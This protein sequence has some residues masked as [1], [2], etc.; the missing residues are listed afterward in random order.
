[1]RSFKFTLALILFSAICAIA[2]Q[3]R[4]VRK[5]RLA[6][7]S[8]MK[9]S[10]VDELL[11]P[12]YP[13]AIDHE[14]GGFFSTSTYDFKP[15]G[16]QD[17]MIV[18]QARHVWSNS[19]AS[20]IFPAVAY[21][22]EGAAHGYRFLRDKMWDKEFGG[23]YTYVDR[24][25]NFKPG[26]FAVKEAYGNSFALY[27]LAAYYRA[28]G[29]TSALN[30]A[31]KEF[32]WLEK[33]SHDPVYK[34][35]F[36]HMER[37]G[38]PIKR[39]DATPS[40][41]ETGYKDQNTS[42]HLLEAFTELYSVWPDSLLKGRLK[43]MFYLIRDK[44]VDKRGSLTLFFQPD[45]TPVSYRDSSERVILNHRGLDHVSFGHDVETAYLMQE[46]SAALALKSDTV[47]K[48]IAKKMVDNALENGWDGKVGGFY[49]EGY[50][51]K[52]K[53]GIT[54]IAESKNWWAQAEGLNTL[55]IMSEMYPKDPHRYY[56]KFKQL[57]TYVQTYLI[58]HEHGDWYPAGIDKE[59]RQ[60]T[61]LKG[62]IWKG[63]Y[64]NLRSLINCTNRLN[65][66]RLRP[67]KPR[68]VRLYR[69][70]GILSLK[71][72]AS[73]DDRR[74]LGYNIYYE[75]RRIGFTPL[76]HWSSPDLTRSRRSM[77]TVR[78]A[79]LQG[80]LSASDRILTFRVSKHRST[81]HII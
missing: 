68:R 31:I 60:K 32:N 18:T 59:P 33:H 8:E 45:W 22:K 3:A 73:H 50:Y 72:S 62:Q 23:F 7:Y 34:G 41:A 12:W 65:P 39:T 28:F 43:E 27:A 81:K 1:M 19:R 38:T 42:I 16:N 51:F 56:E 10:I 75:G 20:E 15:Q 53:P 61:A 13:A 63:T 70:H 67:S 55:L 74:V 4:V 9:C 48:R 69:E 2:Q 17:K 71:W 25:G 76:T 54:I 46:A 11:K 49:D 36:Q 21:Y 64:H 52:D 14:Y 78:A 58:D 79:D 47:T 44:I 66:D 37:E 6:I 24:G 5:E 80:N 35:Y 26:G 40:R 57:W 30:L 77:Y 29:D